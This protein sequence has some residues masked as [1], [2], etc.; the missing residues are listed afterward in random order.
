MEDADKILVY[1]GMLSSYTAD[2]I[3]DKSVA[4]KKVM[5]RWE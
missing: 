4:V 5:K 2:D 3:G 1:F